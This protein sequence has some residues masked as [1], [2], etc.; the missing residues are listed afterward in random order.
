[1]TFQQWYEQ[2]SKGFQWYGMSAEFQ[3]QMAA[4]KA[5]AMGEAEGV[6]SCKNLEKLLQIIKELSPRHRV[7]LL[8]E[9]AKHFGYDMVVN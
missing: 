2:V 3:L 9:L 7:V 4:E 6:N 5:W 8:G 1:M